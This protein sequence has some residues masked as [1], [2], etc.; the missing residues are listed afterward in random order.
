MLG[1]IDVVIN[2]VDLGAPVIIPRA[3]DVGRGRCKSLCP[4]GYIAELWKYVRFKSEF[5]KF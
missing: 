1:W 2:N 3:T 5:A 4:K